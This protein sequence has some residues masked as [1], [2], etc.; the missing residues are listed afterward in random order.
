MRTTKGAGFCVGI[1]LLAAFAGIA[2]A[3]QTPLN[4]PLVVSRMSG[5]YRS[6]RSFKAEANIERKAGLQSIPGAMTIAMDLPNKFLLELKGEKLSTVV[7]SD[8]SSLLTIRPES[9][10]YTRAK[11][12]SRWLGAEFLGA[13]DMPSPG[14]TL[15]ARL[16]A[17]RGRE[18]ELGALLNAAELGGPEPLGGRQVYTLTFPLGGARARVY[19]A[20]DDYTIR[21]VRLTKNGAAF[22]TETY[23]SLEINRPVDPTLF[24]RK[25]PEGAKLVAEL[26]K[27]EPLVLAKADEE[28]GE[29]KTGDVETGGEAKPTRETLLAMGKASFAE[30]G[31]AR[32]HSI[33]GQGGRIG[34]DLS[35]AGVRSVAYLADHIRDPQKHT[36]GSRMPSYAGRMS[37]R[38]IL[39]TA[40]YLGSLK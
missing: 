26:P 40:T 21:R 30:N 16:I 3:W 31:C 29:T 6:M 9:K 35:R 23:E 8:G 11:A 10:A 38:V 34:P 24:V 17:G 20:T 39:A 1:A 36:P 2:A 15:I 14:A 4:T 12:P 18:G 22:W 19:V 25:A 33:A 37:E 5:T 32:C 13:M 28:K 27:L 7:V